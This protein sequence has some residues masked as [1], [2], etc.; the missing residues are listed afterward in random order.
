MYRFWCDMNWWEKIPQQQQNKSR[1]WEDWSKGRF[2]MR[3]DYKNWSMDDGDDDLFIYQN[4]RGKGRD[5][6]W[7]KALALC[8]LFMYSIKKN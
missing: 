6:G 3:D 1:K 4:N 7:K 5:K 8:V 2:W